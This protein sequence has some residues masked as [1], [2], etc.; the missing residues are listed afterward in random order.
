M[1]STR[2]GGGAAA[3][4]DFSLS[5][6]DRLSLSR[7]RSLQA[8]CARSSHFSQLSLLRRFEHCALD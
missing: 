4:P 7:F 1:R 6:T 2:D 8:Q 3:P 5:A